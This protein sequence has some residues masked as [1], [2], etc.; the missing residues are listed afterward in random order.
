MAS[1]TLQASF[2]CSAVAACCACVFTNPSEVVKTRL[3]LDGEGSS[4]ATHVRQYRGVAH[5]FTTIARLEGIRGLQAGLL[6]GLCYQTAMNGTRLGMYEP[7]QRGLVSL[8]GADPSSTLLKATAAACSGAAG[9]MLGSPIYLIKSRLQAQSDHFTVKEAARYRGLWDGLSS[10]FRAEGVA[11]LFRGLNGAIPRIMTGSAVQLSSYDA[12]K[13]Y[14]AQWGVPI[15]TPQHLVASLLASVLTV[16]AMNPWDV[17]STRLYQSQGKA[18]SYTG[19]LDCAAQTIR[20]EGWASMQKGW[21][22]QYARLGPHTVLTFLFLEQLR[23]LAFNFDSF[24]E[25]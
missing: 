19:P 20:A 1:L 21:L 16:T 14:A 18:T 13:G 25:K 11:G 8:T 10:V 5:A 15:G 6:P 9:G 24:V 22:A 4:R 2:A 23:P 7:V 12:C 17:V 3:Q